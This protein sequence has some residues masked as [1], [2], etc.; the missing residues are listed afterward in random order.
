MLMS[1][2]PGS[3]PL[4]ML[5][6]DQ[7][8]GALYPSA[9]ARL[10][11]QRPLSRSPS[12]FF[13]LCFVSLSLSLSLALSLLLSLYC[14]LLLSL[15]LVGPRIPLNLSLSLSLSLPHIHDNIHNY[16]RKQST[17]LLQLDKHMFSTTCRR[18]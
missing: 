4:N 13:L 7:G 9:P 10:V 15:A 12:R 18:S 11:G 1:E 17:Y 3:E 2:L 16:I 6:M 5:I 8:T 14:S